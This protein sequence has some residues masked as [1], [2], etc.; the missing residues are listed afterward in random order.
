MIITFVLSVE[1]TWHKAVETSV[2]GREKLFEDCGVTTCVCPS[3]SLVQSPLPLES[4]LACLDKPP[5]K[6]CQYRLSCNVN[7]I[8]KGRYIH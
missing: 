4:E 7:V 1:V 2:E 3:N 8:R 6:A 5:S